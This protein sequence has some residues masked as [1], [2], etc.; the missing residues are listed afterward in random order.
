MKGIKEKRNILFF[1]LSV[2][3]SKIH[4]SCNPEKGVVECRKESE[5]LFS[6]PIYKEKNEKSRVKM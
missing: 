4:K 3:I 6:V 5:M 1:T 2:D